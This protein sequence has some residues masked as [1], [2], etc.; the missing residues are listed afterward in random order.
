MEIRSP[1]NSSSQTF[2]TVPAFPSVRTTALPINSAC[3]SPYSFRIFDARRFTGMARPC[4]SEPSLAQR[5]GFFQCS[6]PGTIDGEGSSTSRSRSICF[7]NLVG[8]SGSGFSDA[9][10]LSPISRTM[11]RL[12]VWSMSMRLGITKPRSGKKTP[13]LAST[14]RSSACEHGWQF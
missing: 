4:S 9:R 10:N 12:C 8:S 2:S 7:L 11:A 13:A 5:P 14:P 3:A 6:A 1:C